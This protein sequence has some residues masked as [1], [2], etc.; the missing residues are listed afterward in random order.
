MNKEDKIFVAGHK[1][2]VGS[3]LLRILKKEGYSNLILKTRAELDLTDQQKVWAF[4][5]DES[6][7]YVFLAA[8]KVGGIMANNTYRAGFIADNL[9]IQTN[10]I[11]ASWRVGVKRLMFLG[12]A[13]IYPKIVR[14]L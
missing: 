8:A 10:V 3:A 5:S 13:C 4:F 2:M 6:P 14:S 7:D 9:I 11:D 12:S 1:G